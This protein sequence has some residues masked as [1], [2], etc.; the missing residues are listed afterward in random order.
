VCDVKVRAGVDQAAAGLLAEVFK[1]LIEP[2]AAQGNDGVGAAHRPVH[3]GLPEAYSCD[4]LTTGV[5]HAG[6]D[7]AAR[8]SSNVN[9][10]TPKHET[11]DGRL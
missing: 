5:D 8:N 6:A 9:P 3:A 4:G 7:V 11:V 1:P 2:A 10:A